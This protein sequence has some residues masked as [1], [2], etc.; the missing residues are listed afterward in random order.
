MTPYKLLLDLAGLSQREAA[1][2]HGVRIDTVKSWSVGRNN[3]PSGALDELAVLIDRQIQA[4]DQ[5]AETVAD[6]AADRGA[7]ETVEIGL[8]AD[9]HEAQALGW[10][11]AGAH[12]RVVALVAK[13][14]IAQGLEVAVAPR[15]STALTAAAADAHEGTKAR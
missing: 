15:G 12:H 13:A 11:C 9:D 10:P 5:A 7:P 8:A 4:A 2:F 14:L 1:A 6:Q 3:A